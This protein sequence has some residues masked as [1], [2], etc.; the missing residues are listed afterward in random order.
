MSKPEYQLTTAKLLPL[1]HT[2]RFD[3]IAQYEAYCSE[4]NSALTDHFANM[5]SY[6]SEEAMGIAETL[7]EDKEGPEGTLALIGEWADLMEL[8]LAAFDDEKWVLEEGTCSA[9]GFHQPPP[10]CSCWI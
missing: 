4:D 5:F 1:E 8:S 10:Y 6:W 3:A 9:P 7:D 2:E